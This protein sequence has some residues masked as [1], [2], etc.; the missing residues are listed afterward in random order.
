MN[1]KIQ[2]RERAKFER[3][4]YAITILFADKIIC[5]SNRGGL[6]ISYKKRNSIM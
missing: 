3:K 5:H 6:G 2:L 4:D 1:T